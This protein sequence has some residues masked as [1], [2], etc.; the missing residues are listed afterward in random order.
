MKWKILPAVLLIMSIGTTAQAQ[1]FGGITRVSQGSVVID[2]QPAGQPTPAAPNGAAAP[3]PAPEPMNARGPIQSAPHEFI[4]DGAP[5]NA[6]GLRWLPRLNPFS[7]CN[8]CAAPCNSCVIPSVRCVHR[9]LLLPSP[10]CADECGPNVIQRIGC[11]TKA[12]LLTWRHNVGHFTR[13][14]LGLPCHGC[15]GVVGSCGCGSATAGAVIRDG[16]GLAPTPAVDQDQP[17][18]AAEPMPMPTS[19]KSARGYFY[20]PTRSTPPVT[21]TRVPAAW[22]PKQRTTY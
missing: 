3:A 12:T 13:G 6:C 19:G 21:P 10:C 2:D 8:S 15:G 14:C 9:P 5:C 16:E 20:T 17:G 4:E 22:Q 7:G 18:P 1:W 11:N